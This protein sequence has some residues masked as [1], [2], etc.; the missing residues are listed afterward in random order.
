MIPARLLTVSGEYVQLP[1]PPGDMEKRKYILSLVRCRMRWLAEQDLQSGHVP[2]TADDQSGSW[3]DATTLASF[4]KQANLVAIAVPDDCADNV[5][6]LG[7]HD[8][9][10]EW[11]PYEKPPSRQ[12]YRVVLRGE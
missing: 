2:A 9:Y 10:P 5:Y 3:P 1:N 6:V 12:S 7:V 8:G 4:D 11:R